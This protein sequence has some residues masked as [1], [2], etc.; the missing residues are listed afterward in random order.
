M[1]P[2]SSSGGATWSVGARGAERFARIALAAAFLSAVASRFGLW[3]GEPRGAAFAK[4][5]SGTAQV[6]TFMP[7][8]TIPAFAW[9]ATIAETVL[10][11][12]LLLGVWRRATALGAAAL[13]CLFG[14]SMAISR[15]VKEPLDYSVFSAAGAALLLATRA[16][17]R[18][19]D[20]T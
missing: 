7:T 2:N 6:L 10:A 8:A 13:L 5:V 12:A 19:G 14:V 3:S 9:A 18:R 4:F 20:P 1:T 16:D 17:D 11:V 15:G